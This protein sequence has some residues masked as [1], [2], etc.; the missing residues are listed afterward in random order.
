V[1]GFPNFYVLLGPNTGLGHNSVMWMVECQVA[2]VGRLLRLQRRRRLRALEVRPQALRR[3][4]ARLTERMQGM[5][6]SACRSWYQRDDGLV[7][8]L[9]PSSTLRYWWETRRPRLADFQ[10][11]P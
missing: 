3:F 7:F 5:V 10:L 8:A 1:P 11:R 6:W 2:Y 4:Y 9:W